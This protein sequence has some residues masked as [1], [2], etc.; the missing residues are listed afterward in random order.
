M[1]DTSP[2][3]RTSQPILLAMKP[4]FRHISNRSVPQHSKVRQGSSAALSLAQYHARYSERDETMT[5]AYLLT[6]FTVSHIATAFHVSSS[7][8]GR[9]GI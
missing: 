9:I 4:S 3:A 1:G 7:R 5:R 2:L 8:S 6:A